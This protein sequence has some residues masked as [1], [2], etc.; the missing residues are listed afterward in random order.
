MQKKY[1]ISDICG[2]LDYT[3]VQAYNQRS[4][5]GLPNPYLLTLESASC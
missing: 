1:M 3:F 4:H 5:I 2:Y